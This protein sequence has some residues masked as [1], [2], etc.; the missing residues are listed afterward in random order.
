MIDKLQG[1]YGFTRMPFGLDLAPSMQHRHTAHGGAAARIT[2][3]V[4]EKALGV[5]RMGGAAPG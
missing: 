3:C 4:T 1:F 5:I 2:W